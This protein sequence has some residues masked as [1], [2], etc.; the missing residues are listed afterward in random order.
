MPEAAS[1]RASGG[2]EER[3]EAAWDLWENT[4]TMPKS[5]TTINHVW[6]FYHQ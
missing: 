2:P 5:P 3:W 6:G 4:V 1:D